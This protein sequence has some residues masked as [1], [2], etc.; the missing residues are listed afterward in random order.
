MLVLHFLW[1]PRKEKTGT[2]NEAR[3][4]SRSACVALLVR[5]SALHGIQLAFQNTVFA[6][7][8]ASGV[9]IS[10]SVNMQTMRCHWPADE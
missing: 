10:P 4:S 8:G 2:R 1:V 9:M 6:A 7:T 3:K 5:N